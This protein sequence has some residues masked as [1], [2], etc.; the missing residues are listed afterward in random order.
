M[1]EF[2]ND[3]QIEYFQNILNEFQVLMMYYESALLEI[4]TKLKVMDQEF[5]IEHQRNPF[6]SIKS[7][8][9][10]PKSIYDKLQRK[11]LDISIE[12]IQEHLNDI[13][14]IRVICSFTNDIYVL[15]DLLLKQDDIRLL[16]KRDFIKEPKENGYRSLHLVV[17]V[18]VF[19]STGKQYVRCEIQFR[20][21]AMDFW[22]SLEH[23][24][25][26]KKTIDNTDE[27]E[28]RL[29]LCADR[30]FV[31][32]LEMEAIKDMIGPDGKEK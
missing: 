15:S 29:K 9:K 4:E 14:G 27:I 16:K 13:A 32:D 10:K 24:I 8:L 25:R 19:L 30:A 3:M 22:A 20:T 11:S 12:N 5:A 23:K 17:A 2:I 1:N 26:Y 21:I 18:P 28:K 6:E 31:L 7:R